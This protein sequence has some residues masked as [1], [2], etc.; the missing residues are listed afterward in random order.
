MRILMLTQFY[1]PYIGGEEQVVQNLSVELAAR[2]HNV[3]VA[4]LEYEGLPECETVRGVRIYRLRSS[5]QRASWLYQD[6]S[7]HHAP[8]VPDPELCLGLLRVVRRERPHVVHAHNWLIHSFLPIK[9]MSGA[10]LALSLH[11]YSFICATKK[12]LYR[13]EPCDGPGVRKCVDC[14]AAHYGSVKGTVT[15]AMNWAMGGVERRLVDIFLPVSEATALDNRLAAYGVPY[16]VIPN[17]LPPPEAVDASTQSYLNQLPEGGFI[18]FAGALGAYKGIDVLIQAYA[19]LDQKLP[20]VLIGYETAESPLQTR[21]LPAG[22]HVLRDWPHAAVMEAW[23]RSTL[24]VIPSLV[25][26]TFGMV[27]LEAMSMGSPVIASNLGGLPEVVVDGVTGLMVEP[28]R[29]EELRTAMSR[30]ITHAQLRA[31]LASA[32]KLHAERFSADAVVPRFED[33]Y[34]KLGGTRAVDLQVASQPDV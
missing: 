30:L 4:T 33:V 13:G 15:A 10:G 7:R 23:R 9:S 22:V 6:R 3:A 21:S 18:M 29:V 5:V 11:D 17:F 31:R 28:G 34:S 12:L 32:A 26:E 20:L 27:A 16:R 25:K 14:S 1:P 8:P 2:G 19:G 24:A